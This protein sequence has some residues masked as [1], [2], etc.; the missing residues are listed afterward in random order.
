MWQAF[1]RLIFSYR[2]VWLVLLAVITTFMAWQG[3]K[4][5]MSFQM[6]EVL[7]PGDPTF[8][9]YQHFRSIFGE[10]ANVVVMA[11]QHPDF[12]TKEHLQAW[13]E[14]EHRI[15]NLSG[16]EWTL[17]PVSATVLVK[18]PEKERFFAAPLLD[19]ENITD[20]AALT[21]KLRIEKLPFYEQVLWNRASNT[22]LMLAAMDKEAVHTRER[23]NIVKSIQ[24]EIAD[25]EKHTGL[26]MHV[27]GLPF[28]RTDS[29]LRASKEITLFIVLAALITSIVLFLFFKSAKAIF[30]PLINVGIAIIWSSAPWAC[31]D[32]KFLYSPA[33]F[34]HCLL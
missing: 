9:D 6:A 16:I 17:S 18:D 10:E 14:L 26:V 28:I 29:I 13:S 31:W 24:K 5:E 32:I 20:S 11:V 4:V 33:S 23:V 34:H 19:S 30:V 7:P 8:S 2:P 21:I 27:S 22:F 12:F 1:A 25:Y 15:K 3:R